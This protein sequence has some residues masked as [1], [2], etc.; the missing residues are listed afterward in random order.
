MWLRRTSLGGIALATAI[1]VT[2]ACGDDGP[3][4]GDPLGCGLPRPCP[5]G[6]FTQGS[7]R[8]LTPQDA[9]TCIYTE[10]SSAKPGH[11][12]VQFRDLVIV[13]W[14]LYVNGPDPAVIVETECE[15]KGPCTLKNVKRCM[16]KPAASLDCSKGQ[17]PARV[18]GDPPH[19]WCSSSR[20]IEHETCP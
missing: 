20:E 13:T 3:S 15:I 7:K 6:E 2:P 11:Y 1:F 12:T 5:V 14:D 10:L 8:E 16:L 9:A 18:C 4:E 19:D 17:G